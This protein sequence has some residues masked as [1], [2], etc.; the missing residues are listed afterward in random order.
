M[1]EIVNVHDL[2]DQYQKNGVV[3]IKGFLNGELQKTLQQAIDFAVENPTAMFSNF[4][5]SESGR[6]LFDFLNF[7]KNNFLS[8]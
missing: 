1:A 2:A 7:R 5:Q 3:L 4:S 6:F 8:I